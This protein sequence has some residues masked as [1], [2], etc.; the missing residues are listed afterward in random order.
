M[1]ASLTY[2]EIDIPAFVQNSPPDS[3]VPEQTFRFTTDVAYL[4]STIDAIPSIRDVKITPA[5]VSL[6][7]DLGQ[8]ASV[9][10]LFRDHKHIFA[11]ESY[12]SGTFWGKFRARYGL[13]LRGY[14]LRVLRGVVGDTIETME[15]RHFIIESTD[16]PTT[17]GEYKI[18][19]KDVLKFADGD[20]A[21]APPLSGGFLLS[22]VTI[23]Q[24]TEITLSPSGVGDQYYSGSGYVAI[25]GKEIVAY[26]RL[27]I[28]SLD[29]LLVH[30]DGN[31]PTDIVDALTTPHTITKNGNVTASTSQSKFGG[32][33]IFFDG[34]GD[35]LT[36]D[37][38]SE[39]A[40]GTSDFCVD[41]WI[42][43]TSVAGSQ[44]IY[45]SRPTG[46]NGAYLCI[47][48]NTKLRVFVNSADRIVGA[49]T[50]LVNTWYHVAVTRTGGTTRLFLN[51]VQDGA[52]TSSFT[53]LN[54]TS[55]PSIGTD[56]V[57]ATNPITGYMDE[58]RVSNGAV[59]F[60]GTFPVPNAAYSASGSG[61]VLSII[62]AQ[63]N[64]VA[65]AHVAGDRV[66]LCTE[67]VGEDVADIIYDLLT[68]YA[69][70]DPDFITLANW[71]TET[72]TYLSTIYSALIAEPT[73]VNELVAE[74]IEQ[75]SLVVWW[76]DISQQVRL[77]VLRAVSTTADTYDEDNMMMN[78][79]EVKEQPERRISQVY[80]YFNKINPLVNKD[81]IENYGSTA[82]AIDDD[83]ELEYGSASIK[84][85]FSRW[86]PA[87]G[88]AVAD[89]V[90]AILL[91][92][93]VTPPRRVSF[94]VMRYSGDAP[95][96]GLGY[97]V[98]GWPFQDQTGAADTVPVQIVRLNP[99]AD[100]FEV[101]CEEVFAGA[102]VAGG[103]PD[104][105]V[106]LIDAN[107]Q[108]VNLRDMHDSLYAEAT[109]GVTVFCTVLAGVL[110]G[111]SSTANPAFDVGTWAAGVT[112][113]ITVQGTIE[114]AGG[115][116]AAGTTTTGNAG[117]V[118]GPALYTRR[119]ITLRDA[120]GAIWGG[121][122]GGGAGGGGHGTGGGGG[123]AAGQLPGNGG[124]P[125]G[126]P[127]T[128]TAGG[129]FGNPV[130]GFT[131]GNGRGGN[132]GGPGLSGSSG[133]GDTFAAGSGGA[134]GA[135]IDGIS[136]VTTIGGAGD[137]RGGQIN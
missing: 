52:D 120:S 73:P 9:E 91:A 5:I 79:L 6:G 13:K 46:T 60:A 37:G 47:Y 116:G 30:A 28:D 55:R 132:G 106:I 38:S 81:Q 32:S 29:V 59:R 23:S 84:K 114:G 40:F 66:Q 49:T 129:A 123:G 75:A 12:S 34:T 95:A 78:S 63:Y 117:S 125:G 7:G 126:S 50:L 16:G 36:L 93:F 48:L 110:V 108:N 53:Y 39:F 107:T 121:G 136:F 85:I 14:P 33:S 31:S 98:M 35:F 58:I 103:S 122:G 51:G 4:P 41:F 54:G 8:R 80:T 56:G 82:F 131:G 70:I 62:R 119:A 42:R 72:G 76:D 19:A 130:G 124:S 1:T 127:G 135:S 61:D 102:E 11:S 133:T 10:V 74:L 67:Y 27:G 134:A 77:Q 118:G 64:T 44:F 100:V 112:V 3:P 18:I 69:G 115:N 88:R 71:Q 128:T 20:R 89:S 109:S 22:D 87:G 97:Q 21:Q 2:V 43:F 137:R 45:D 57:G 90:N 86:I 99:R 25:G 83:A 96:L 15:T 94:D 113:D 68:T 92:R 17:K 24:L 111:S 105:H 101:E 26:N 104:S 65:V